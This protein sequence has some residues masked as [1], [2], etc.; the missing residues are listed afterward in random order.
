A[1]AKDGGFC[2][3]RIPVSEALSKR[4]QDFEGIH[5]CTFADTLGDLLEAIKHMTVHRFIVI[6][7]ERRMQG[8]I[9]LS[10]IL[11]LLANK[12]SNA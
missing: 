3:I 7:G 12:Y 4:S 9:S 8:V 1:L 11:R 10:D 6:D 2:D 5:T